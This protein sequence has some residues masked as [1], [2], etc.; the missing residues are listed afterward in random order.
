MSK[1]LIGQ[2]LYKLNFNNLTN[3]NVLRFYYT[4]LNELNEYGK[5]KYSNEE[6]INN[7]ID[8]LIIINKNNSI[9]TSTHSSIK[10]KFLN[11]LNEYKKI[12][13]NR[14]DDY[15][16]LKTKKFKNKLEIKFDISFKGVRKSSK[17]KKSTNKSTSKLNNQNLIN[18]K[19]T[20]R[21]LID[22]NEITS[23]DE[24]TDNKSTIKNLDPDYLPPQYKKK[25]IDIITPGIFIFL[26]N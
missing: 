11:L 7:L 17:N 5:R 15:E 18:K 1:Y 23:S 3:K 10:R 25:K 2:P 20:K 19:R 6:C 9:T 8:N 26:S 16:S 13:R 21:K 12:I 4:H 22:Y 14:R 24:S